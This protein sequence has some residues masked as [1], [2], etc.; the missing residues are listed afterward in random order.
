VN[1]YRNV[2]VGTDGSPTATEAVKAAAG[3][4]NAHGARLTVVTAFVPHQAETARAMAEAPEEIRWRIT[5]S[6]Q[7]DEKAAAACAL[8][9]SMGV[10]DVRTRSEPGD[11]ADALIDVAE[12]TG[13]DLIVV[14]SRGMTGATR[15]FLGSVPNKVSHHAPCD[16]LIVSTA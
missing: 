13:G 6:G 3:L 9:K 16:V 4:A 7:A 1:P 12:D 2:V 8:A 5:E 10:A 11:P 14:G 15:F